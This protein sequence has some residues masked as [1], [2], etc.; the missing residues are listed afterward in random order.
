MELVAKTFDHLSSKELYDILSLRN[1]VFI[2]EQNCPYQDI[3][4]KDQGAIHMFYVEDNKIFA[5][6]R[7]M[8]V[9][10]SYGDAVS[11]GRVISIVRRKGL[12]TKLLKEAISLIKD[13]YPTCKIRLS[14]QKYARKLYENL[15]FKVCS[16]LY[17]EDGI[18]HMEFVLEL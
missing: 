8:D 14:G 15:G 3:D 9:G 2:V 12:A 1:Q 4:G 11:I 5:Y 10:V 17:L 7:I 16:Q 6:L 18:E 13:R